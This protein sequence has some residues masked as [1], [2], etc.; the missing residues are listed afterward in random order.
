MRKKKTLLISQIL[1]QHRLELEGALTEISW[2]E[3]RGKKAGFV[4]KIKANPSPLPPKYQT[5]QNKNK[6]QKL[7]TKITMLLYILHF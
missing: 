3:G 6:K 4:F 5:K 1:F 7:P 2:K